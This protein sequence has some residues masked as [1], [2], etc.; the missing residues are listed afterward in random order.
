MIE[1]YT[2]GSCDTL[3]R[4]GAWV[5]ILLFAGGR[6][7][8]TG[9]EENTTH[10]RMELQAVI[11]SVNF[12]D[13]KRPGAELIVYTDSQYV[14]GITE[15]KEKLKQK[16]FLTSK[17]SLIQNVDLVQTLIRQIETHNIRFVKVKAHQQIDT[18]ASLYNNQADRLSRKM[19]RNKDKSSASLGV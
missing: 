7:V 12:I 16:R 5:S 14:C 18:E 6:I 11:A 2:D 4:N 13:E 1:I 8:L 10:N 3:H 17:G 15:R 9:E 19:V